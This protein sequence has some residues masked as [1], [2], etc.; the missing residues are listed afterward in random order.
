MQSPE[1]YYQNLFG[2]FNGSYR[3]YDALI[4]GARN[5]YQEY[6]DAS[7][8]A[9][10]LDDLLSALSP[11]GEEQAGSADAD[12]GL[13]PPDLAGEILTDDPAHREAVEVDR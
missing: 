8:R 13:V 10:K 4:H 2:G 9:R 5:Q 6:L 3:Q 7:S 1:D 11:E 12:P